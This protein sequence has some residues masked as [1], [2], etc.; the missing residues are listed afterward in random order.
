MLGSRYTP[1]LGTIYQGQDTMYNV[2]LFQL[3]IRPHTHILYVLHIMLTTHMHVY[4]YIIN[5]HIYVHVYDCSFRVNI[6]IYSNINM[7]IYNILHVRWPLGGS[8]TAEW[9]ALLPVHMLITSP[10]AELRRSVWTCVDLRRTRAAR[11]MKM[12]W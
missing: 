10:S 1:V 2:Q 4:I 6:Y 5:I 11:P 8:Q 9:S 3:S 12:E 7:C